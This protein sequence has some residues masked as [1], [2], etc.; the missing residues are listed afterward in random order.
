MKKVYICIF[1]I[2]SALL[3]S[4]ELDYSKSLKQF[5]DT[6]IASEL[7][8]FQ[9][10][11]LKYEPLYDNYFNQLNE[12][13]KNKLILMGV[14]LFWKQLHS[15]DISPDNMNVLLDII[16]RIKFRT[17]QYAKL[18]DRFLFDFIMQLYTSENLYLSCCGLSNINFFSDTLIEENAYKIFAPF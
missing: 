11:L 9:E 12:D 2:M 6:S 13:D 16:V 3:Y 5:A 10:V 14:T 4:S 7:K 18:T 1:M 17:Q 15:S 8:V